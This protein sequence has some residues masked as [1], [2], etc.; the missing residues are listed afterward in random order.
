M[1]FLYGLGHA[2]LYPV[3]NTIFVN[4]GRENEKYTLNSIFISFYTMGNFLIS[5]ALGYVGD[6][7]GVNSIYISMAFLSLTGVLIGLGMDR[8]LAE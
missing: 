7:F 8:R 5:G 4:S 3:L 1:G 2:I 6:L